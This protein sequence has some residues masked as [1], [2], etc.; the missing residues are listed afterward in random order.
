MANGVVAFDQLDTTLLVCTFVLGRY[1]LVSTF[2]TC[3]GAGVRVGCEVA[4][5]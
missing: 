2:E 3:L 1:C 4:C 5:E